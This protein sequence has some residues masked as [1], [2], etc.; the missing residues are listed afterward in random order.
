MAPYIPLSGFGGQAWRFYPM[1]S[2]AVQDCS[3]GFS[4]N[5]LVTEIRRIFEEEFENFELYPTLEDIDELTLWEINIWTREEIPSDM[6]PLSLPT[7][8][9]VNDGDPFECFVPFITDQSRY[10]VCHMKL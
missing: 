6:D 9:P 10:L 1:V 3:D 5:E 7:E 8:D 4:I 2:D